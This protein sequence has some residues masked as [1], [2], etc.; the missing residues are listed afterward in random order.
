MKILCVRGESAVTD[1]VPPT[2]PRAKPWPTTPSSPPSAS[3]S[4]RDTSS[5]RQEGRA[6]LY[7]PCV[8]EREAGRS[9][10]RHVL[11]RFF[12]N[13][14]ERLLL[15]LLG[16]G[17]SPPK[18][19]SASAKPSPRPP[20]TQRRPT[21]AAFFQLLCPNRRPRLPSP[22]SGRDS[23]SPP[24]SASASVPPRA[25]PPRTASSSGTAGFAVVAALPFLP[26][27]AAFA[28]PHARTPVAS[29]APSSAWLELGPRWT[30]AI[31]AFWLAA[32]LFRAA[33]LLVHTLRSAPPLALRH[34]RRS[35][36][37]KRRHPQHPGLHHHRPR[38]PQR[39]RLLRPA[40][41]HSRVALPAPLFR[42][43]QPDR[44]PRVPAPQPPRRLTNLVQKLALVLF[45]LN[46]ALW[47]IDRRLAREREMACDEGVIRITH[48]PRALRRLPRLVGRARPRPPDGSS[49]PRRIRAPPR[50]RPPR[51]QHPAQPP[52]A[53]SH[54]R[55]SRL[56]L[57]RLRPRPPQL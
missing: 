19:S 17:E 38:P 9:E 18:S 11:N 46:P 57:A 54:R 51:P 49:L 25:S 6:F 15:S 52:R 31:A 20:P 39:H 21:D 2:C 26:A 12:G 53:P 24:P 4:R 34:A 40:H 36:S 55:P 13:S 8:A 48:A 14:R 27:L 22:L 45:P 35:A 3:S 47:I 1:L 33:D 5:H 43:A 16:D 44:P 28:A 23:P 32:S 37:R 41:P 42:R 7:R 29:P 10:V 56:R 30:T 50:A